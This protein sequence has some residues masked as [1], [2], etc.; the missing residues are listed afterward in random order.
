MA[1][2]GLIEAIKRATGA[3]KLSNEDFQH[4][5]ELISGDESRSRLLFVLVTSENARPR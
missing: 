1:R 5:V 3:L 4:R 2:Y